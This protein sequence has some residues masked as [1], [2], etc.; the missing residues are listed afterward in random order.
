MRR[1]PEA[2]HQTL[3]EHDGQG[4]RAP[5]TRRR[6]DAPVSI[7]ELVLT[8]EPGPRRTGSTTTRTSAAAGWSAS[9]SRARIAA[10]WANGEAVELGDAVEGIYRLSSLELDRATMVR[11]RA[12]SPRA[13]PAGDR[14]G[15]QGPRARRR[16]A[17]PDPGADGDGREPL[18]PARDGDPRHRME[19]DAARRGR[20]SGGLVEV[21]GVRGAH[22][23]AGRR[24]GGDDA[25]PGQRLRRRRDR[26]DRLGAG[27]CVVG[28]DRD[29]SRTRRAAS[30]ASTRAP[31]CSSPGRSA[32]AAGG[33]RS[34]TI[35]HAV[36]T[37]HDR[38]AEELALDTASPVAATALP[39]APVAAT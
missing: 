9:S 28:P 5:P 24:R 27:R 13:R 30:S 29:R 1:R 35:A 38:A 26:D 16:P 39:V 37:T 8:K 10:A 4:R 20:Q 23:G 2:Y 12:R 36:S 31:A 32:S 19:P 15:D 7:H 18:G 25:R 21:G 17:R 6:D 34:V 22:D 14:P 33:S 3:R 11:D